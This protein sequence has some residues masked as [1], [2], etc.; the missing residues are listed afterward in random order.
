MAIGPRDRPEKIDREQGY[1]FFNMRVHS[2]TRTSV[3]WI[4]G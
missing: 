3:K 1:D 4:P 2:E